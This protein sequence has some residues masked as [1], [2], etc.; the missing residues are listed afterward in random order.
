MRVWR[1]VVVCQ[2]LK[3]KENWSASISA[4]VFSLRTCRWLVERLFFCL[5]DVV[6]GEQWVISSWTPVTVSWPSSAPEFRVAWLWKV[7][8][9][10]WESLWESSSF[11][12]WLVL[13]ALQ[14]ASGVVL[15]WPWI[16]GLMRKSSRR[17]NAP[18]MRFSVLLNSCEN[19]L[20]TLPSI[21][22]E[23][24]VML[25]SCD[26]ATFEFNATLLMR[27]SSYFSLFNATSFLLFLRD[28]FSTGK[29][30][31]KIKS[32]VSFLERKIKLLCTVFNNGKI[33]MIIL[34]VGIV[35]TTKC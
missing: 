8:A 14:D 31:S 15:E 25:S 10:G 11:V 26:L 30:F 19:F 22:S 7:P 17:S 13:N 33:I 4:G 32:W 12:S 9:S 3:G 34:L 35:S 28:A 21:S 2:L 29:E 1:I 5:L 24:W 20:M 18:N 23:I 27:C 6:L 16:S